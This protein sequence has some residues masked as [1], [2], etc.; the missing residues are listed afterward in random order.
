MVSPPQHPRHQENPTYTSPLS[1][2][3]PLS[4]LHPQ[5][6]IDGQYY[7]AALPPRRHTLR[8]L[9]R[10]QRV[11][12]AL[13]DLVLQEH[14]PRTGRVER[15]VS[16]AHLGTD[17]FPQAPVQPRATFFHPPLIIVRLIYTSMRFSGINKPRF[18]NDASLPSIDRNPQSQ[19]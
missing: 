15:G 14:R 3:P 9:P 7:H 8:D 16:R 19:A 1:I 12:C 13:R 6:M 2:W 5:P 17:S 11:A 4:L 18:P 10:F